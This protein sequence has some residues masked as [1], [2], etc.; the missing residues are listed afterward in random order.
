MARRLM[1]RVRSGVPLAPVDA[2][3]H[4]AIDAP[5]YAHSAK[6]S[7]SLRPARAASACTTCSAMRRRPN[8]PSPATPKSSPRRAAS[9]QRT[10]VAHRSTADAPTTRTGLVR[11]RVAALVA[12]PA[13][14]ASASAIAPAPYHRRQA[15][16]RGPTMRIALQARHRYRRSVTTICSGVPSCE[17]GPRTCRC[18]SPWPTIAKRPPTGC[19]TALQ[20][21]HDPGRASAHAGTAAFQDLIPSG[22]AMNLSALRVFLTGLKHDGEGLRPR[23]ALFVAYGDGALLPC[24]PLLAL[25][26]DGHHV[27]ASGGREA[28]PLLRKRLHAHRH[29]APRWSDQEMA[30]NHS[31]TS[32]GY[33]DQTTG[34]STL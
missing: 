29:L 16:P 23:S 18:T 30:I 21:G 24:R 3:L 14:A 6:S 34:A 28:S 25:E 19:A 20:R 5:A 33:A 32:K 2:A 13:Y 8:C 31:A 11:A 12:P 9:I 26:P 4:A 17:P 15:S 27:G 22:L 1:V 7:P 10:S